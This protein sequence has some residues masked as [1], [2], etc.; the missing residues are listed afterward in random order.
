[1]NEPLTEP[2]LHRRTFAEL[3]D[4][5]RQAFLT[6]LRDKREVLIRKVRQARQET[7]RFAHGSS[8]RR[9]LEKQYAKIE[10]QWQK[11]EADIV[12][13]EGMLQEVFNV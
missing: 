13:L 4:E 9:V 6:D 1:M 10:K 3:S 12:K 2:A 11:T 5:E 7:E 8:V